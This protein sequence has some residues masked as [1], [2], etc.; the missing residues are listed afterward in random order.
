M[1]TLW[2]SQIHLLLTFIYVYI[3]YVEILIIIFFIQKMDICC[4]K[5]VLHWK[6]TIT[7]FNVFLSWSVF[8]CSHS[9]KSN[10]VS[11][12]LVLSEHYH[13]IIPF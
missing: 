4:S 7:L 1:C 2:I 12:E 3:Y 9:N 5:C 10:L 11:Q 13:K 6:H 8:C